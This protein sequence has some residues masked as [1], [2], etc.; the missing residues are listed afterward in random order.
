MHKDQQ[1]LET[2]LLPAIADRIYSV[3]PAAV[4]DCTVLNRALLQ[5]PDPLFLMEV[6]PEAFTTLCAGLGLSVETGRAAIEQAHWQ[7]PSTLLE[8]VGLPRNLDSAAPT[9]PAWGKEALWLLLA[10]CSDCVEQGYGT[11]V[12]FTER[13]RRVAAAITAL[14]LRAAAVESDPKGL[15]PAAV[16]ILEGYLSDTVLVLDGL[17]IPHTDAD[18]GFYLAYKMS[19]PACAV[20]TDGPTFWGTIA[21]TTL[22]EMGIRV[23][24]EI[25]P[26][27]G[28]VFED[29]KA[30]LATLRGSP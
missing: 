7:G 29:S 23:D 17:G 18:V 20:H 16:A 8:G 4:L 10:A 13:L 11:E 14:E 5:G 22:A 30:A 12:T 2:S 6:C 26:H 24:K 28:L 27:F 3:D 15:M 9:R 1:R 25:S 21:D 19:H